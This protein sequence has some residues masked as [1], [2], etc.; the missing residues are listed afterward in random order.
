MK[1]AAQAAAGGASPPAAQRKRVSDELPQCLR[2]IIAASVGL[3]GYPTLQKLVRARGGE[4]V[5]L[6]A[7]ARPG[8]KVRG[9]ADNTHQ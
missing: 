3:V 1:R 8:V 2:G 5:P 6:D 7:S 9:H 4:L